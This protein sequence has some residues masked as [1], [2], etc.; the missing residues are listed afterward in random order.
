MEQA[1]HPAYLPA[2][3]RVGT[4][5]LGHLLGR[6]AFGTVY[7]AEDVGAHASGLAALKVAHAPNDERFAREVALLSRLQHPCIPRLL[8]HG[9]WQ[10]PSGLLHPFIAME[11]VE[12]SPLYEWTRATRP[13]SREVL[14]LL[15][16][17]ARALEAIH[18]ARGV[19]RD[20]KG[21]NVL[22]RGRD[23][24]GVLVDFGSCY[25]EGA[26]SLTWHPF[27]PGTLAYRPPEAFAHSLQL[28][29]AGGPLL[30]YSARPTD[31]VFALGVTAWRLVTGT[32][33]PSP[34]PLDAQA[35]VWAPNGPGP[36]PAHELNA[37]CSSELSALIARMLSARPEGRGSAGE[38][39]EALERT[40]REAGLQADVPLFLETGLASALDVPAPD[41]R[42][43]HRRGPSWL[44][45]AGIVS[46]LG[47]AALST[48]NLRRGDEAARTQ[49]LH[50]REE[51]D[52]GTVGVGDAVLTAPSATPRAPSTWFGIALDLPA[53]PFP[54][55]TR[56]DANGRCRDKMQ[57][58]INGGCWWRLEGE[59]KD[60]T[61]QTYAYRGK[62][63][64]P[65]FDPQRP[66]TSGP[67]D[68]PDGGSR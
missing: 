31:D 26:A 40:A 59:S 24:R 17:L 5:R 6:G 7:R 15:A 2:G 63:Y 65:A 28:L 12:G 52:A 25:Y 46:A 29:K 18:A 4:W 3:T 50:E 61:A 56:P 30:A 27:P 57:A 55:Q 16:G 14:R 20:V 33:P 44:T 68:A 54:G 37:R 10:S 8:G 42:G 58:A 51:P 32:Y 53:R 60:C 36:Q 45:A 38:L 9:F 23:G 64:L 41:A 62:C 34:Q 47:I 39:A 35:H 19:H 48:L 13:S 66:P 21:A 22:V 1:L 49:E 43:T 67:T 11:L